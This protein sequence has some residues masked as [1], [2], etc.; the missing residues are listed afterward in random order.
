[1]ENYQIGYLMF[2]YSFTFKVIFN[3]GKKIRRLVADFYA[4]T[5][6]TET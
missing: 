5:G 3:F 6:E 4:S 2:I 1:M